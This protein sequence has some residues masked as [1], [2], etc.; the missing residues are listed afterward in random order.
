MSYVITENWHSRKPM[1]PKQMAAEKIGI[2]K[3]VVFPS[4][5][6]WKIEPL[7]QTQPEN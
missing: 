1:T 7:T 3:R 6:E 2:N 5:D 4:K